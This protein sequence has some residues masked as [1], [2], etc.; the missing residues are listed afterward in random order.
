MAGT[1]FGQATPI[2]GGVI[3]K[4]NWA[5]ADINAFTPRA[6]V[7]KAMRTGFLKPIKDAWLA[8]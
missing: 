7:A 3:P 6:N 4:W 8:A 2:L 1:F 5:F